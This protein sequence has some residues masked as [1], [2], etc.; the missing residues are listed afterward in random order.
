MTVVLEIGGALGLYTC[1]PWDVKDL[2]PESG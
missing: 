2:V 1:R